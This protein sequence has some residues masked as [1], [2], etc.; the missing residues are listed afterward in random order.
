M[1]SI[2]MSFGFTV[3][4]LVYVAAAFSG[5]L[6]LLALTTS[7]AH[8]QQVLCFFYVVRPAALLIPGESLGSA[9]LTEDHGQSGSIQF[10]NTCV[11]I[12]L[13]RIVKE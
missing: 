5:E 4:V 1:V 7:Y 13:A 8:V 10:S 3:F 9:E 11:P 6:L 2:A 12:M